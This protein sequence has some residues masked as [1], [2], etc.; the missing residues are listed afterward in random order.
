MSW[1]NTL[2]AKKKIPNK[3]IRDFIDKIMETVEDKITVREVTQHLLKKLG[4][5]GMQEKPTSIRNY[6]FGWHSEKSEEFDSNIMR[7][8]DY[9]QDLEE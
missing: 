4:V 2:K 8:E 1:E 7:V 9:Y 5:M 3:R 6:L